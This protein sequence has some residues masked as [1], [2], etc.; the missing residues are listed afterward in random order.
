[1]SLQQDDGESVRAELVET[2]IPRSFPAGLHAEILN[3]LLE[4]LFT[5]TAE[6][7]ARATDGLARE[8]GVTQGCVEL[9][10]FEGAAEPQRVSSLCSLEHLLPVRDRLVLVALHRGDL[11]KTSKRHERIGAL[12]EFLINGDGFV[13][14]LHVE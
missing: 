10:H 8:V 13:V 1:M 4:P 12:L 14:I 3:S 7:G 11:R 9:R 5:E 6:H 2:R